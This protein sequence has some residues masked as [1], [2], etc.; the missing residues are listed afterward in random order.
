[1]VKKR[2]SK[3]INKIIQQYIRRLIK[4]DKL[5]IDKVILFGSQAKGE[6]YKWSDIDLCIISPKFKD[7]IK[8]LEYLW[9]RRKDEEVRQGLEPMG[10][11]IED[12]RESN[13]LIQE[14]K[15]TGILLSPRGII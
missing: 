1:M 8:A 13:G 9:S 5:P 12:F 6:I 10:F 14:I 11:S 2:I 3:K 15:K 4:E 7:N